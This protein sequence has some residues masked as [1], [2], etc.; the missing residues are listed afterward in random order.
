M[1]KI[2]A[3]FVLIA[4]GNFLFAAQPLDNQLPESFRVLRDAV[5]ESDK[6]EQTID[7]LYSTAVEFANQNYEGAELLNLISMCDYVKGLDSFYREDKKNAI[8]FLDSAIE[9]SRK[10]Q[11]IN[12]TASSITLLTKALF[13]RSDYDKIGF[14]IKWVPKIMK[15]CD[16]AIQLNP[17]YTAAY[18]MKYAIL[19]YIP[20]P[21]GNYKEGA[22]KMYSLLD[23]SW[24]KEKDDYFSIC[25]CYAYA[26]EKTNR[27]V[28][29]KEWYKKAL[30][31]YP[32]N[33]A[34]LKALAD[35]K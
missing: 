8:K 9:G 5:Y 23:D 12:K 15:I 16:E 18:Q 7:S 3:I 22:V 35:C 13:L 19:C 21:Y 10:S 24:A 32:N 2:I 17:K 29:A 33:K 26:L 6:S 4:A 11:A 25:C 34:C 1:K 30:T 28:E 14:G 27:K 20:A 31:Y